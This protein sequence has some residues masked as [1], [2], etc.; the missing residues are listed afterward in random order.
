MAGSKRGHDDDNILFHTDR[1]FGLP[2]WLMTITGTVIIRRQAGEPKVISIPGLGITDNAIDRL[3]FGRRSAQYRSKCRDADTD[4]QCLTPRVIITGNLVAAENSLFSFI[5]DELENLVSTTATANQNFVN[6]TYLPVY[7]IM[8]AINTLPV[9]SRIREREKL[10]RNYRHRYCAGLS[11]KY[12]Q[13]RSCPNSNRY[14][15][16][17]TALF[18]IGCRRS[19]NF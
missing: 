15:C 9:N 18:K 7:K 12:A 16:R 1:E 3:V 2:E 5:N 6:R 14:S 13:A 11:G 19:N 17:I 10:A 8:E 4:N